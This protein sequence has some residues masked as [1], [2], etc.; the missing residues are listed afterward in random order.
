MDVSGLDLI[1]TD[2]SDPQTALIPADAADVPGQTVINL[3]YSG[4]MY[5]DKDGNP[6]NDMAES[7][8]QVDD[9]TYDV[10]IRD[11]AVFADGSAVDAQDFVDTWNTAVRPCMEATDASG[12]K[13][14]QSPTA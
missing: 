6:H 12:M 7:V 13:F 3:L 2:T 5:L 14:V 1:T 8:T 9:I 4:L 11:D 10:V